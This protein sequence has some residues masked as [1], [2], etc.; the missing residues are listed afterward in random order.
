MIKYKLVIFDWDGTIGDTFPGA[1]R[2]L[3]R[4][5]RENGREDISKDDYSRIAHSGAEFLVS[6]AMGIKNNTERSRKRYQKYV[7]FYLDDPEFEL[8]SGVKETLEKMRNEGVSLAVVSNKMTSVVRLQ[9][10]LSGCETLFD[11]VLCE[12]D[13]FPMKPSPE[14]T[15]EIVKKSGAALSETLLVGDSIIDVITGRKCGIDTC[16]VSYGIGR[17]EFDENI[18]P[19]YQ[20][21]R[22]DKLYEIVM[23]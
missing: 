1:Y 14:G 19:D 22:F 2:V 12:N 23:V 20:I 17:P 7:E 3:N 11:H 15:L 4:L 9:I 18:R 16:F 5:L 10:K 6:S 21:D 8:F 13:G